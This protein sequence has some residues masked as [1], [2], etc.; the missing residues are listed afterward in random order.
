MEKDAS[1]QKAKEAGHF[2][3]FPLLAHFAENPELIPWGPSEKSRK[4]RAEVKKLLAEIKGRIGGW[5]VWGRFN[6]AAWFQPIY[7]GMTSPK[8]T[9][10][11][12][13]RLS[14]ELIKE[15]WCILAAV[16]GRDA[17]LT[18]ARKHY[19]FH[20][21][22]HSGH[23]DY[24]KKGEDVQRILRRTDAQFI[25]WI[26]AGKDLKDEDENFATVESALIETYRPSNNSKRPG[27]HKKILNGSPVEQEVERV[28]K[29]IENEIYEMNKDFKI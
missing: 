6:D 20:E 19:E 17:I 22:K 11:L 8:A 3:L 27:L 24:F 18:A 28:K 25:I 12:H 29:E 1:N 26:A 10:G 9:A 21:K 13:Q 2:N 7:I 5:Y 4:Y 23:K 14:D 15:Y 16:Y